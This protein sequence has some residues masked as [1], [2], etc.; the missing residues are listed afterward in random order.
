MY[1]C[2][3]LCALGI[4]LVNYSGGTKHYSSVYNVENQFN[5]ADF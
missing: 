1:V 5:V 3:H 4:K 2:V